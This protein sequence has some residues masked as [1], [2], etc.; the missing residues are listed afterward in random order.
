MTAVPGLLLQLWDLSTG[1]VL[2]QLFQ[3][4]F[5]KDAW[6][7]IQLSPDEGL[8]FHAAPNAVNVYNPRDFAAGGHQ[9]LWTSLAHVVCTMRTTAGQ[10]LHMDV[11]KCMACG[12]QRGI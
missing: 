11:A 7:A 12:C 2:L 10:G 4:A 9:G 6:P 3:K 5:N 1:D 8:A